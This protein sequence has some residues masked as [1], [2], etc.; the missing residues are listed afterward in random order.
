MDSVSPHHLPGSGKLN[1]SN[2][3]KN[4]I[5]GV[6]LVVAALG[7]L[8][9]NERRVDVS[10]LAA[11]SQAIS[12]D[13]V[14]SDTSLQGQFV[15]VTGQLTSTETLSDGDY[16]KPGP[17]LAVE[18]T[19]EMYAWYESKDETKNTYTYSEIWTSNPVDSRYFNNPTGHENPVMIVQPLTKKVLG[20]KVGAYNVD[21]ASAKLPSLQSLSLSNDNIVALPNVR[22][23]S[24]E[25]LF[26]GRGT[27]YTP[28]TGDLRISYKVLPANSLA[29][30]FGALQGQR[31]ATYTDPN[32][33]EVYEL[34]LG[35]RTKALGKLQSQEQ[36][37]TWV[38]RVVGFLL[39]WGGLIALL[40]KFMA[41]VTPGKAR[42][43]GLVI[44]ALLT[45][46]TVFIAAA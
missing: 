1:T 27:S 5:V 9:W 31:I 10:Q 7:L 3:A 13:E 18:R 43:I 36:M 35:D 4:P 38:S 30:V 20:A 6:L 41:N 37:M 14:T 16:L 34:V 40:Q 32:K 23:D 24:G 46:G 45:V 12:G 28:Q 21:M 11:T 42:L 8:F 25:R 2:L 44:A 15:S 17:Y 39:M 22:I 19:V 29:T 26:I 33:N